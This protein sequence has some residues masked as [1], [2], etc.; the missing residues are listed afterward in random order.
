MT[1]Q[2]LSFRTPVR[3]LPYLLLPHLLPGLRECLELS[4]EPVEETHERF[5]LCKVSPHFLP[6]HPC[7]ACSAGLFRMPAWLFQ[8]SKPPF[9]ACSLAIIEEVT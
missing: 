1:E 3:V 4:S 2:G 6:K 5:G 7:L 9:K 8:K